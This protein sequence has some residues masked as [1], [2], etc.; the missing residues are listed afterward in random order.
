MKNI[1]PFK[2]NIAVTKMEKMNK[3]GVTFDEYSHTFYN[4]TKRILNYIFIEIN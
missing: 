1:K 4:Y 2:L 3:I